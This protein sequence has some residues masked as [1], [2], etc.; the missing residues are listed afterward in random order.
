MP[1][2]K[3]GDAWLGKNLG[4]AL[5]STTA[6]QAPGYWDLDNVR[7]TAVQ[8]PVLLDTSRTN[9]QFQFTLKSEPGH[10]FELFAATNAAQPRT[11]WM[12][13][14]TLTNITG[15]LSFTDPVTNMNQRWYEARRLP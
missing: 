15:M 12:S 3:P 4:I 7:L 8:E 1:P 2:V 13:L 6:F 11:N 5:L 9:G 10:V 14:G